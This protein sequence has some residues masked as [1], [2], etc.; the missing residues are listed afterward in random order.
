MARPVS[1]ADP[2]YHV[3]RA[4]LVVDWDLE[5]RKRYEQPLAAETGEF[6][7][8]DSIQ[9]RM[10]P[11]C[12][13]ECL[14]QG[15][16][17]S[18]SSFMAAATE[19][20]VKE[21]LSNLYGLTR[22]NMPGGSVHSVL[23][24]RFRQ[25]QQAEEDAVARG[26]LVRDPTSGLLPGEAK[27]LSAREPLSLHDLRLALEVGHMGLGQFPHATATVMQ[28]YQEGEYEEYQELRKS[29]REKN[30]LEDQKKRQRKERGQTHDGD[31]DTRM[32]IVNG[33]NGAGPVTNGVV[34]HGLDEDLDDHS[35]WGW[36]GGG[37]VHRA[38]LNSSLDDCLAIGQ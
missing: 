37:A 35:D 16:A 9:N 2:P 21:L 31:G 15:C 4:D 20:F 36:V 19:H 26:T 33:V 17:P 18:C 27:E 30:R 7:D 29:V 34:A 5:I 10:L 12:Y 32:H 6:P 28:G 8:A 38:M 22:A 14:S 23:T 13:E 1:P 3:V 24:R 11:I 25:R